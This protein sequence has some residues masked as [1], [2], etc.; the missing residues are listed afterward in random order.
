MVHHFLVSCLIAGTIGAGT[1][2]A[3]QAPSGG[4]HPVVSSVRINHTVM[5]GKQ[6]LAP[7]T[8]E[9][10]VTDDRPSSPNGEPNESQRY[11]EFVQSGMVVAR[12]VAEVFP[13]TERPVGTSSA[14]GAPKAVV[15]ILKGEE[16]VRVAV[17]GRDSRYLIHLP[18]IRP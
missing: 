3:Q 11:V 6:P 5:A 16:F 14:S 17:N 10:V 1:A 2:W 12:E 9:L 13:A 7:G 18:V 8:Y 15:E 4:V